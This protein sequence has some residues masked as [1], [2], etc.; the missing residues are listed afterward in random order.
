[1]RLF[2]TTVANTSVDPR[3]Q[4]AHFIFRPSTKAATPFASLIR[5]IFQFSCFLVEKVNKLAR[6]LNYHSGLC[7]L[8]I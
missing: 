4:K 2:G 3:Y 1:M 8:V 6:L 7:Q 5:F